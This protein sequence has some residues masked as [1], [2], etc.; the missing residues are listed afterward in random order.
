[1]GVATSRE[2]ALAVLGAVVLLAA[3]T[4]LMWRPSAVPPPATGHIDAPPNILLITLDTTRADRLGSYGYAG[5]A[6][7]NLDRLASEGVRFARALSPVPLTLPAHASLLT[8]RQPFTHGVRNNGHFTLPGDVPTLASVL[9]TR[10]YDTAAFVS[11][12]VLDR[13]FGLATGFTHYDAMLDE[14]R[15]GASV[16][17]ELERRGDRTVAAAAAW[18]ADRSRQARRPYFLWVHL[19]DPHEPYAAPSPFR[20][21]FA[22]RDYDGEVAFADALVGELLEASGYASAAPPLVVVAGDHGE[23]LGEHGES[24][25]GLFVYDE[26][27]RVP[28]IVTWPRVLR[29]RVVETPV[30]L[31]DVGPTVADL[32]AA[33]AL[34][35]AEG[36]SLRPLL[37]GAGAGDEAEVAYAET[38]FPQF[39]MRWAPLRAVEA[40]RWKYIDAPEPELYDLNADPGEERNL[41]RTERAR[42][43]ALKRVLDGMT[44]TGAGRLAATPL[45]DD[46]RER[47]ASLGYLSSASPRA[48]AAPSESLPDP[49]RMVALYERLLAAN[50]ALAEGN[51]A[52][53]ARLARE[54]LAA[55]ANNPYARLIQGRA[56]LAVGRFREAVTALK[57]Y[58]AHVPASAD[59]HHWMALAYLRLGDRALA[60]A[61][62]DAA[63]A[64]DPGHTGAVSLRAGL[65]FSTGKRKE[66]IR[67]LREAAAHSPGNTTL[68]LELADLLTD[69]RQFVDAEAEFRRVLALRPRDA[70]ALLGLALVL[71]A[72]GRTADALEPLDQ[73]VAIDPRDEEARFAR[74]EILE[75][76]G[77]LEAARVEYAWV[78]AQATRPDLRRIAKEKI[79]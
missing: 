45:S 18:L 68:R 67:A 6:T 30:R 23:S 16:S 19:Y 4:W 7:P 54:V 31:L 60:L 65:L 36:R 17:L 58:V 74:A 48:A 51:A 71:G 14:A 1:M 38:Y 15:P 79:R 21:R 40:G 42:A 46:A 61:E 63:L 35:G 53:A 47:L 26:T 66:G 76:L 78:V 32:V 52:D 44:G 34:D 70:R 13:Q 5:A 57:A 20:E 69:A 33:P 73:A 29:P 77:K 59:A 43:A 64:I 11:S 75:Q 8:G 2:R 24:T 62:E 25:H 10:G 9:S 41:A 49:K 12:F 27:Q 50:R 3:F 28:L 37:D 56:A 39:F 55:D 22:G 72:T